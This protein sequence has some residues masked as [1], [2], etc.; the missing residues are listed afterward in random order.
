MVKKL[1][2]VHETLEIV[3]RVRKGVKKQEANEIEGQ[4]YHLSS[5]P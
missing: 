3:R 5:R 4:D 1:I 2:S